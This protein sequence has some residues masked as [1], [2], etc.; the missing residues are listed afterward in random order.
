[1]NSL[2]VGAKRSRRTWRADW[3]TQGRV[4]AG[5]AW[6]VSCGVGLVWTLVAS[7]T[8]CTVRGS[9]LAELSCH[10]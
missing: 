7:R 3:V 9:S 8:S 10:I 1:M 2:G 4:L 5:V 6:L